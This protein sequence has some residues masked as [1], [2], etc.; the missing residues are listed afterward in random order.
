MKTWED[1]FQI[2][3]PGSELNGN[4]KTYSEGKENHQDEHN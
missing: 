4:I 3:E 1:L 2:D